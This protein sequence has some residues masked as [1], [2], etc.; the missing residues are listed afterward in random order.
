M[1]ER[2]VVEAYL[3][4]ED[5]SGDLGDWGREVWDIDWCRLKPDEG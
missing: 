3:G 2:L 1:D 5:E 4:E